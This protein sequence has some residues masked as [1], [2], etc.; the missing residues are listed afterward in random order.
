[1]EL[2]PHSTNA[3]ESRRRRWLRYKMRTLLLLTTVL[4]IWLGIKVNQARRQNAAGDAL[5]ALG[6]YVNYAHWLVNGRPDI[7]DSSQELNVPMWLRNLAGD[8]FFQRVVAV[9]ILPP[10]TDDDLIHF[11]ALPHLEELYLGGRGND[12]SDSGLANLPRPDRLIHFTTDSTMVGDQ[13]VSRLANA[14]RLTTLGVR[15]PRVTDEGLRS[16]RGLRN[17][18]VLELANTQVGDSGL[19]ALQEMASLQMLRLDHTKVTDAGLVHV[20]QH[21]ALAILDLSITAIDGSGFKHLSNSPKIYALI[22]QGTHVRGPGLESIAP[23]L[24]HTLTLDDTPIDDAGL[25]YLKNAKQLQHLNLRGTNVTDAG[26]VHLHGLP[27]L[28][29]IDLTGTQATD[30]GISALK[31]ATPTLRQIRRPWVKDK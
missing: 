10:S 22:L 19:E 21:P 13:F 24:H 5:R 1:M 27:A 18:K 25:A 9:R 23:S 17:V 6:V 8:D 7:F 14:K 28:I 16:L 29:G 26:L 30:N 15:G 3:A 11:A 31:I 4:G 20:S 2:P 12:I